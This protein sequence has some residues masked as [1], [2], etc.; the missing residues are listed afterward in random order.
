MKQ[1]QKKKIPPLTWEVPTPQVAGAWR[2]T[3]GKW[4]KGN[5]PCTLPWASTIDCLWRHVYGLDRPMVSLSTAN[6]TFGFST[7]L[8]IQPWISILNLLVFQ[9]Q[10]ANNNLVSIISKR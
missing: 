9:T 2:N 6:F 4:F 5:C 1:Q 3:L 10:K 7:F 8:I